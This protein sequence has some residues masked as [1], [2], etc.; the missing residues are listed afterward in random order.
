MEVQEDNINFRDESFH[1]NNYQKQ[2]EQSKLYNNRKARR[3][4]SNKTNK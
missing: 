1:S 2:L 3:N 4:K